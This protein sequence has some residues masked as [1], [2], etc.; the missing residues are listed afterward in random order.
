MCMT[1]NEI[2]REYRQAK[3][4]NRQIRIL[5]DLNECS[6]AEIEAVIAKYEKQNEV[7]PVSVPD[8]SPPAEPMP[9]SEPPENAERWSMIGQ[10]Y[11]ELDRLNAE[12]RQREEQY[13]EITIAIKVLSQMERR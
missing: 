11:E 1:E 13:R 12:I 10:L 8:E 7:A 9:E 6:T 3:H 4:R 2:Y 5:A